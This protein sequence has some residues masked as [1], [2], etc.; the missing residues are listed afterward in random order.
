[1]DKY[2]LPRMRMFSDIKLAGFK[3]C[4]KQFYNKKNRRDN[5]MKE[6]NS[7]QII[8]LFRMKCKCKNLKY[9]RVGER[10]QF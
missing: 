9:N 4:V 7:F 6:N 1:M 3:Y 8:L 2:E 5:K 10:R